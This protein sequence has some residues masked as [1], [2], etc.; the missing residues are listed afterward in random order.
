MKVELRKWSMADK[1]A[2]ISICNKIDRSYLSDRLPNPYT[3]ASADWW[4][5]RVEETEG[6]GAIFRAIVVDGKIIGT[7][8]VE[9]KSDVYR[10]DGEVGYYLLADYSGKGIMSEA[11]RQIC[12]FAFQELDILRITGLVYEPHIVSRRVLEKNGFILEGIMKQAVVKADKI[13]DLCIYGKIK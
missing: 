2:L 6:K 1:Q 13:Y 8:S 4:L 12:E 10:K 5:H 9:Q 7:I 11:L 3:D